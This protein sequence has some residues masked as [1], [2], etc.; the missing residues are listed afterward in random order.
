MKNKAAKQKSKRKG[1]VSAFGC[2]L[3]EY[4]QSS[5]QDVPQVLKSCAEFIEEHGIV[6]GIYRLSGITSNIQRLRQEF[7]SDQS[8]DL[9]REVYL[10]DIHCVGSLCKLYFRELPNPLL[11]YDLYKKF[12]DAVAAKDEQEQLACI[13]N[14]IKELPA[15]HYRTLEYLVKHLTHL[16]SFSAQTNMH[17]RNLALVW[18]PNLLRSKEIEVSACNGDAAFLEVRVQQTVVE[19]ILIHRD[20]IF[21]NSTSPPAAKKEECS[22][23]TRCA[24][25]PASGQCPPMKL[26]SLEEAQARSL[27]PNHPARRERQRENS[28][29]DA[30]TATLYHTVIDLPDSKRKFSGKSKKWK[31]IFNLGRSITESKGKLSRN[32]SVFVRGQKLSEKAAIR[33]AKSMDSLCSLPTE[34]DDKDNE[35]KRSPGS[36]GLFMPAFKSRT[37]GS[38]SSYDLSKTDHEWDY[39]PG[40]LPGAEG[41]GSPG[42]PRDAKPATKT[43]PP[44]QSTVPEQLKVFK[45]ED[46]SRCEPTS[47]K[48]RRMFYSTSASDGTSKPAFPGSLFPLESSPRHQRKALNISEPFAVSVPLRVSAVISS[49]STPCRAAGK[50]KQTLLCVSEEPCAKPSGEGPLPERGVGSGTSLSPKRNE[51]H[52]TVVSGGE[53]VIIS[54]DVTDG[55]KGQKTDLREGHGQVIEISEPPQLSGPVSGEDKAHS[56]TAKAQE[57]PSEPGRHAFSLGLDAATRTD[58]AQTIKPSD[59]RP[60]DSVTPEKQLDIL[61]EQHQGMSTLSELDGTSNSMDELWPE[62]QLE[63]KIIEPDVDLIEDKFEPSP[64]FTFNTSDD[65]LPNPNVHTK[66]R[67]SFPTYP[68]LSIGQSAVDHKTFKTSPQDEH[69]PQTDFKGNSERRL[70]F[71]TSFEF[72]PKTEIGR[73]ETEQKPLHKQMSGSG[74]RSHLPPLLQSKDKDRRPCP[75]VETQTFPTKISESVSDLTWVGPVAMRRDSESGPEDGSKT[76]EVRTSINPA[77]LIDVAGRCEKAAEGPRPVQAGDKDFPVELRRSIVRLSKHMEDRPQSLDL[78]ERDEEDTGALELVEPW[79]DYST[80]TQW[81]T[82]PLHSPK[83]NDFFERPEGVPSCAT[84]ENIFFNKS[85]PTVSA[86]TRQGKKELQADGIKHTNPDF[87]FEPISLGCAFQAQGEMSSKKS[88]DLQSQKPLLPL[89]NSANQVEIN[90]KT[91]TPPG[92]IQ[93]AAPRDS[94][95]H[96]GPAKAQTRNHPRSEKEM[97]ATSQKHAVNEIHSLTSQEVLELDTHKDNTVQKHRP[98]SLNL[99]LGK[100]FTHP[101]LKETLGNP[102][103]Q[104]TDL[105]SA[106]FTFRGSITPSEPLCASENKGKAKYSSS[107]LELEMFLTDRQAPVRRNSA[108]VSV[109]SIRT[110]FMVKTCQARAVPVIPPKIQ[111]T[112]IPQP[113]QVKNSECQ[114]EK[115][116]EKTAGSSSSKREPEPSPPLPFVGDPKDEKENNEPA[117]KTIRQAG[118]NASVEMPLSKSAAPTDPPVLRR[119]RSSNGEAF[120]DSPLSSRLDRSPGLQKP[121]F[122]AR[123]N[124]PQSLILFS[125]PF[126]IMDHPASGE[127]NKSLLSPIKSPTETAALDALSKE[128]PDNLKTPEG[129]TL[130]N[131]MTMPKSGQRLETSTSC[132]YQPQRR[133]MIFD[134]RSNRQIE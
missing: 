48:T 42:P 68:L 39:E 134:S 124:R 105:S 125:P 18:A 52:V 91:G 111:Y 44:P 72:N 58:C 50:D 21:N 107:S 69:T 97:D 99:D 55:H 5:G 114:L 13:Q 30:S 127:G 61:Q 75:A 121:S 10:Q 63:L 120:L 27:G 130:R 86:D 15:S 78:S 35:F 28:L 123:P 96:I 119:K 23:E 92:I 20:Q 106:A 41:G 67:S 65:V 32:G 117:P 56:Q 73:K 2:D 24:A 8:P 4:L 90:K 26:V 6:D 29:P 93:T 14:V 57:P 80:T 108:P 102:H 66:R 77:G 132:F 19:F 11:T 60:A 36:S 131:K 46:L 115:E 98:S 122:R 110:S 116:P 25:L 43:T 31:S 45:G 7:G 37:L 118:G 113:L 51:K 95:S 12:T 62:I 101:Y 109:S 129:V 89:N 87:S 126:P 71:D 112:Q 100:Q 47:P 53:A 38:G 94:L 83:A 128:F 84:T 16:A 33:P 82:S 54:M 49:N 74:S 79:E 9:T 88:T 17:A 3:T 59:L 81:V 64:G 34:D 22:T 85:N 104:N 76:K 1:S 103:Q 70:S 133:S 40:Q